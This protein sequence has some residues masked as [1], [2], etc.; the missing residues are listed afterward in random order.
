LVLAIFVIVA[1]W[2]KRAIAIVAIG[3][4]VIT[5]F[6]SA[7]KIYPFSS[8]LLIFLVPL[9][10]LVIATAIDQ[11]SWKAGRAAG[12]ACAVLLFWV[13]VAKDVSVALNPFSVSEMRP[14][15]EQIGPRF[16]PGD[17]IA[18]TEMSGAMYEFYAPTLISPGTPMLGIAGSIDGGESLTEAARKNGYRRIWL[19][20]AHCTDIVRGLVKE[21]ANTAP[22]VFE[23]TGRGT[24]VV[25]FDFTSGE[26]A[27]TSTNRLQVNRPQTP[28]AL[29]EVALGKR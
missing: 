10:F 11:I 5:V 26:E 8:R 13:A 22:V 16:E 9:A 4:I 3:G 14:A 27:M 28:S 23:W 25:L 15:L 2:T 12:T 29:P 24:R 6:A 1:I 18:V 21:L 20:A 7:L 19:V 17:A